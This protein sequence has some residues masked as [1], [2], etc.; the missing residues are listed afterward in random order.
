VKNA[1]LYLAEEE[2]QHGTW[3][4]QLMQSLAPGNS[5]DLKQL[6]SQAEMSLPPIFDF[7]QLKGQQKNTLEISVF[8]SEF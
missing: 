1:F 5:F 2:K 6:E 3:L 7:S 8:I 4:R